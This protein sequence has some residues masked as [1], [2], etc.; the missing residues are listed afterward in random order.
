M[1]RYAIE[2]L[3]NLEVGWR[4]VHVRKDRADCKRIATRLKNRQLRL[5]E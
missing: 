5:F 3:V 4:Y 2:R 1:I